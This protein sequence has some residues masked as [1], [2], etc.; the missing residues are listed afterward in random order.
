MRIER[1]GLA[2]FFVCVAAITIF[3]QSASAADFN[4]S[5]AMTPYIYRYGACVFN[6]ELGQIEARL[7]NCRKLRAQIEQHSRDTFRFWHRTEI[8]RRERQFQRILDQLEVEARLAE[9]QQKTVPQA[10]VIYMK[11]MSGPIINDE[12]FTSGI[13]MEFNDLNRI[14]SEAVGPSGSEAEQQRGR[15]LFQ[16]LRLRGRETPYVS[17][18]PRTIIYRRGFLGLHRLPADE[19]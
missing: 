2:A 13:S 18:V 8:P 17:G 5:P 19:E 12:Q 14:C 10:I 16:R 15:R 9:E 4:T 1:F 7:E 3:P 11:C 6:T